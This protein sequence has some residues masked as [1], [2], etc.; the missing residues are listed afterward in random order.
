MNCDL[1]RAGQQDVL[2]RWR[3]ENAIIG[4]VCEQSEFRKIARDRDPRVHGLSIN[5]QLIVVPTQAH[6]HRPIAHANQVLH[7]RRLLQVGTLAL[8]GVSARES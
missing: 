3:L 1:E 2:E 5:D 4:E 6:V 7:E 8:T